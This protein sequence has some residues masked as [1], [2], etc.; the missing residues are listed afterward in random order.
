MIGFLMM[1]ISEE[2][3]RTKNQITLTRKVITTL[4]LLLGVTSSIF[5][6]NNLSNA[7]ASEL[8]APT[9]YYYY[10]DGKRIPLT[11]SLEWVSVR[12]ASDSVTKQATA[13]QD[14]GALIG[15]LDQARQIPHRKL[16]LLPLKEGLTI[17]TIEKGINSLRANA[18][19]FIQVNPVFQTE[20]MKIAITDEFIA[21]FHPKKNMEEIDA[22]N[23]FHNVEIVK[24]LL[25]MENTFVLRILPAGNADSIFM[26]NLY[27]ESGDATHA[28]P[29]FIYIIEPSPAEN[30]S[31]EVTAATGEPND[32]YYWDQWSL[33]NTQQYGTWMTADA[34]IDAPEAWEHTTGNTTVIIAVVD[35]GVD[36][37]HEDLRDKLV[38]GHDS[39]P[40]GEGGAPSGIH[41][42]NSHGTN[43][44]GIIAASTNN[45]LG[46]AGVCQMCLIMPVRIGYTD[47]FGNTIMQPDWIADGIS[48]AYQN[49]A[50]ILNFSWNADLPYDE[51]TTAITNATTIGRDFKGSVV[52]ASVGNDNTEG[53]KYPAYLNNVIAVGA[54]NMCDRRK[55]PTYGNYDLCNG[56]TVSP[57]WGSNYGSLLDISAPGI[58][59]DSTDITGSIG[60]SETDYNFLFGGTSGAAPIVS[61]VAG[62]VLSVNAD[63]TAAQVQ[64]ILQNNADD[65]NGFAAYPGEAIYP[66]WDIYMGYGRVN[67]YRAVQGAL[68]PQPSAEFDSWP[69]SGNA[70]L[71]TEMHIVDTSNINR[72]F[73]NYGDGQTGTTCAPFHFHT[74]ANAGS[75]SVTLTVNGPGGSD[76]LTR[77]NYI[78]VH[79]PPSSPSSTTEVK[80]GGN[81]VSIYNIPLGSSIRTSYSGVN[82]GP[83]QI[84]STNN[85][86]I[87]AAMRVIWREPGPRYSYSELMG[88]PKE[89]LSSEYWF[90]WYN[91][92]A[93]ASM[94]QSLRFGNVDSSPTTIEVLVGN[95][96]LGSY[97]LN[98]GQSTRQSFAVNNGPIRIRSIDGKNIIAAM[99]VIWKE[100]GP[101]TSYTELM[102]L[103]KEQL[104]TEYWFPWYNN[105]NTSRDDSFRIANVDTVTTTIEVKIGSNVVESFSLGP[106]AS[107][108]KSYAVGNGPIRIRSTTGQKI[109]AAMRMIW[110]EPGYRTSYT[111]LM[112]LPKERLSTEYWFPWY[113]NAATTAMDQRFR[114][115]NINTSSTTVEISVGPTILGTYTLSP[116]LSDRK[117]FE[118]VDN[119]P[120]HIYSTDGKKF[121]VSLI[122]IWQETGSRT[123]YSE[124][125]GLPAGLLSTEYWFPWYNFAAPA[126]MDQGFRI[127]VP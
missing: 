28:A 58:W 84:V 119:G 110:Q 109:I 37:G 108:R 111:E 90:P 78:V 32:S 8:S 2:N 29:N 3:M 63:L 22:I 114:I 39:T 51:I 123:S 71:T 14:F 55:T 33:N 120:I 121:I 43:V 102:G 124:M 48:W 59:L 104:S 72:C 117:G 101:R 13:L 9:S 99:R 81:T 82:N 77:P 92:L 50:S 27:Q 64:T 106:G 79:N 126:S 118:G 45:S 19:H 44:A 25:G 23:S 20:N 66:G 95:T 62:L 49:G 75:Y 65:V 30:Q 87:L 70:R 112:G 68:T 83:V 21:T 16:T 67:A 47:E 105:I 15:P 10:A 69:T 89:Q 94:D 57:D 41:Q 127:G 4:L 35:S 52:V 93:T 12:F 61:G 5:S 38:I 34:D 26:A 100:P 97:I 18:A 73:W 53:I 24:P 56:N 91:N 54:S 103:P 86:P 80:I 17:E 125:M 107:T 76:T 116:G 46:V 6:S 122:V 7:S 1:D 115:A 113:N 96:V 74:Y 42:S 85:V 11:P 40:L 98:P 36:L 60:Y 31:R 88:L